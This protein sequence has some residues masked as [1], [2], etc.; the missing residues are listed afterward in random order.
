MVGF[1]LISANQDYAVHIGKYL[2]M[3]KG[4]APAVHT[5][6]YNASMNIAFELASGQQAQ[7][8]VSTIIQ[9]RLEQSVNAAK[10]KAEE[11]NLPMMR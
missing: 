9:E 10:I 11:G 8:V 5:S 7:E 1:Q 4:P 3:T 6:H 2:W